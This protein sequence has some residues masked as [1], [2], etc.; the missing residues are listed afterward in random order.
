MLE[1]GGKPARIG[2]ACRVSRSSVY[3]L[4][5]QW[6]ADQ[7]NNVPK[8]K[9]RQGRNTVVSLNQLRRIRMIITAHPFWSAR[10]VRDHHPSLRTLSR[11]TV[12]N[13]MFKT[14]NL[15]AY[16]SSQ[17]PPLNERMLQDRKR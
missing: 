12:S 16:R 2:R 3:R 17:K 8:P 4:K 13:V 9:R 6:A 1:E 14:L 5:A 7:N 10:R 15:K 11:R